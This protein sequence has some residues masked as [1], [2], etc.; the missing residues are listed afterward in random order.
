M[1]W[2][3]EAIRPIRLADCGI[4]AHRGASA[5]HPE[6]TVAAI[7]AAVR[8]G[9]QQIELDVRQTSDGQLV[10]M[11]DKT[12]DRTTNGQGAVKEHSLSQIRE[13]DAGTWKNSRFEGER[14]PTLA[15][16]LRRIPRNI[17]IN[18]HIKGPPSSAKRAAK[19]A[20][21]LGRT[22]QIMLAVPAEGALAARSRVPEIKIC[23]MDRAGSFDDYVDRAVA[24]KAQFVQV[25]RR[26]G[27]PS[28]ESIERAH[29]ARLKVNYCTALDQAE[30]TRLFELGIDFPMMDDPSL[31][32]RLVRPGTREGS[33]AY[34]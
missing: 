15:G 24:L 32:T 11:H 23:C 13:L 21:A 28:A 12:L 14:V 10:V 4:A 7:R 9:V 26:D 30:V 22:H 17:W 31:A 16:A 3:L 6:N 25:L 29:R 34:R 5:T 18:L 2:P 27:V 33:R 8:L 20:Y 19:L 1:R